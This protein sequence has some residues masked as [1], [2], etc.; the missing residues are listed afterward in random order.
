MAGALAGPEVLCVVPG[1]LICL[2]LAMPS[3][4]AGLFLVRLDFGVCEH[5]FVPVLNAAHGAIDAECC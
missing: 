4:V 1:F 3:D 2:A 5:E